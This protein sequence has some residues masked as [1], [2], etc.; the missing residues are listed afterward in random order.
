MKVWAK[1]LTKQKIKDDTVMEFDCD[2]RPEDMDTWQEYI[3]E[4]CLAL[5]Q[6]RPVILTKHIEQLVKH[7]RTSFSK[8]DFLEEIHFEKMEVEIFGE[9]ENRP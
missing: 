5:K 9:Q 7:S 1:L 8:N 6:A 3:G 2:T 4:L